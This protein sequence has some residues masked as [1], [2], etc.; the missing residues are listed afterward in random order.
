MNDL[1]EPYF[2]DPHLMGCVGDIRLPLA[3]EN[4]VFHLTSMVLQLLQ[5]KG[6]LI[7]LPHEDPHD[8]LQNFVDVCGLLSLKMFLRN[9]FD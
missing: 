4:A 1:E 5:L 8:H 9:R 6:L 3:E 7:K 2:N